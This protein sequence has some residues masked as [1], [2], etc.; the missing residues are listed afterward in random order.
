ML[1]DFEMEARFEPDRHSEGQSVTAT[2]HRH[3]DAATNIGSEVA[4]VALM[5]PNRTSLISP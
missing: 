1:M 5:R 4:V 2:I 3:P